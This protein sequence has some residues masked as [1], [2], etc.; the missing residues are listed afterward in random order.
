MIKSKSKS[1]P[2][3]KSKKPKKPAVVKKPIK[4]K[5][6]TKTKTKTKVKKP[7]CSKRI[8]LDNNGSTNINDKVHEVWSSWGKCYNPSIDSKFAKP[9]RN[10]LQKTRDDILAHCGVSTATHMAI[11]NEGGSEGNNFIIR[12]CVR[13]YRKKLKERDSNLLPH[14]IISAMEHKSII[15][16]VKDLEKFG[17]VSASYIQPTI[18][19][20]ILPSDVEQEIRPNTCLISIMY[21]NNEVP[22]INNI[23]QIGEIAHK[24]SIPLHSDCVQIF[25]KYKINI[26]SDN[27]DVLTASAHKFY[28]PKGAGLLIISNDLVS[29]YSL[30][31]EISGSQQYGLRGGTENIPN[32][33]GLMTAVKLVFKKRKEKN[34]KLAKMREHVLT[35]LSKSYSIVPYETYLGNK[36]KNK[37]KVLEIV[38]LGPPKEKKGFILPNTLLLA[39][40]KNKGKPFCNVKLKHYLDKKGII[41]SVGSACNTDDKNASHVLTAIGAPDVI[42]RGVIRISFGDENTISEINEFLKHLKKGI[43]QQCKDVRINDE[44]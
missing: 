24:K 5:T 30:T 35:E 42:K 36:R 20:N 31:G 41:I 37:K 28:G 11:F 1:K 2:K 15:Q 44:V 40:C 32:I 43:E 26:L 3:T 23:R 18:Y 39:I 21:A 16:C 10:L 22:V 29:G 34:K 19:G 6:K 33:A 14:I 17:E 38:S 9:S 4:L 8:Y 27:I 13:A 7:K 12:A 25:G